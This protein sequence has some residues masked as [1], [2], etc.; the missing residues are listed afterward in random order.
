MDEPPPPPH[1]L[2]CPPST[3]PPDA[4][5]TDADDGLGMKQRLAL[6][7]HQFQSLILQLEQQILSLQ[8]QEADSVVPQREGG[9]DPPTP[10]QGI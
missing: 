1:R 10:A 4:P 9:R 3:V 5:H 7:L 8:A 6:W 2:L